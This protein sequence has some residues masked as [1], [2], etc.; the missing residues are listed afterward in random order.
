MTTKRRKP[1]AHQPITY[2]T[3]MDELLASATQ[4]MPQRNR[5]HQLRRMAD[6]LHELMHAPQPSTN[7]WRVVS[8]AVNLLETLVQ[9]GEAPIKDATGNIIA[10]H[11][12]DCDG[13]AVEVRD[14]SGLLADAIDAMTKAGNRYNTGH[15]LRLDGPGIHAVRAAFD[16]YQAALDTLPHRTMVRCHRATEIRV[17]AIYGRVNNLPDG[18][19]V[20]AI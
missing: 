8:D 19:H 13:D 5:T 11:W 9:H 12:R 14:S 3:L 16:D 15:P 2:Y 4:P 17:K 10:S 7:A 20:M 6:A 1:R 18:V